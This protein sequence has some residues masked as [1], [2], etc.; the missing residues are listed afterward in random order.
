VAALSKSFGA[1]VQEARDLFFK[2]HNVRRAEAVMKRCLKE[3]TYSPEEKRLLFELMGLIL[4]SQRR[5]EEAIKIYERIGDD[6]QAGYCALL[7]GD[8]K[9]VQ[10]YWTTVL[11]RQPNHWCLTL[12]GLTTQQLQTCPTLLQIRH[13]LEGDIA[14]LIAANRGEQLENL[15]SYS[16]FLTQLNLETPKFIGR[17]LL[18]AGRHNRAGTYLLKAQSVLPNDPEIYYHLAQYSVIQKFYPQARIMLHQCLMISAAYHP[19][20]DLLTQIPEE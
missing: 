7:K 6:Y 17:A 9:R 5:F 15:L 12:Y 20:A 2:Q 18:N 3:P 16:D 1:P 11:T 8:L 19:A 4:R 14:C 13:Y 10:R